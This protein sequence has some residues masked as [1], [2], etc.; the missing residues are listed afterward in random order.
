[1][2]GLIVASPVVKWAGGKK[3]LLP[4][5]LSM[6]PASVERYYEPFVGGGALFFALA[7]ES[8][9]RF[10]SAVLADTNE[11][12]VALYKTL[13]ADVDTL[14]ETLRPYHYNEELFYAERARDP[15]ELSP[16]QRAARLVFL[17]KTCFN[18]LWRVN[19]RG[20]FN[21]P[22]GRLVR[23]K[24]LDDARLRAAAA[25][26]KSTR[27]SHGDFHKTLAKVKPGDFVYLDPPYAP[28]SRTA[29]FTN[30]ARDGFDWSEQERLR[31]RLLELK[32]AK[33]AA[34]LSNADTPDTRELYK[35]FSMR[36]VQVRRSINS[37]TGKRGP[38]PEL[39]VSTL[40]PPGI[41]ES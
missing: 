23:P 7:S 28:A 37:N 39:L 31:D 30:Y 1:M 13:K 16:V 6:V 41:E 25:A 8:P 29:N 3:S 15:R 20:E 27:V 35:K 14:I 11:D 4:T 32:K 19:S 36:V 24:I 17:N 40:G 18:G 10:K 2:H 38:A 5:L 22:F 33:V 26:L 12:L 21:V 34:V 9:R